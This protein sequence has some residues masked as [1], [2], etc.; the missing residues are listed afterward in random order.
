MT[1]LCQPKIYSPVGKEYN[2]GEVGPAMLHCKIPI[3][4][5]GT[6]TLRINYVN[7]SCGCTTAPVDKHILASGDTAILYITLNAKNMTGIKESSIRIYTNMSKDSI[8]TIKLKANVIT[9]LMTSSDI[10]QIPEKVKL[11]KEF[12]SEIEITNQG[13]EPISIM[14]PFFEGNNLKVHFNIKSTLKLKPKEKIKL[15][16][17]ITPNSN[18]QTGKVYLPTTSKLMPIVELSLFVKVNEQISKLNG[19]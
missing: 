19:N 12:T 3:I 6:D 4:N 2:F 11:N 13:S 1:A 10:F 7:T 17:Y 9:D 15:K 14:K 5:K 8:D 16:A 18:Y